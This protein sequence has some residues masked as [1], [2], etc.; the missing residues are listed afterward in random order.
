MKTI[1]CIL[2]LI[3]STAALSQVVNIES[4]RMRSDTTGWIG[5][6]EASFQFS[7]SVD[8]IFDLGALIHLQFKGKNDLW[9]FLNE[10]RIIKGAGTQFVN[11]GFA[12]VRYNRKITKEFLRWEFFVQYQ[13]NKALEVGQRVLAGTGPRFKLYDSDKFRAYVA[14]L[15]MFEYQESVDKLIIER[16]HR[17][18]S[19]LS[20]TFDFDRVEFSN[21]IY[22]QPNMRDLKDYRVLSQS[23][24]LFKIF[25]NLK[26]KTGFNYRFDTRPFPGVPKTTYYLSNGLLFEF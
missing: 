5:T 26:F 22:F 1:V 11:S 8:E 20:F 13:Y 24:L 18:S 10:M 15:Y 14:S 7:K 9:L 19:Y 23:D 16:N 17:T 3:S 21:T 6:A 25:E 2:L 4:R 12:H